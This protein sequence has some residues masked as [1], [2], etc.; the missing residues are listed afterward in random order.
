MKFF[1]IFMC[2]LCQLFAQDQFSQIR[3]SSRKIKEGCLEE[4]KAYYQSA[5]KER[6]EAVLE[7]FANEGMLI[8]CGFIKEENG[9]HYLILFY[10][11]YDMD[12]AIEAFRNST[13]EEDLLHKVFG[14]KCFEH[15]EVLSP[16]YH[17]EA[18]DFS[19]FIMTTKPSL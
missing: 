11:A 13:L 3:C 4:V 17:L 9:S 6:R 10:R 18:E 2:F 5:M 8:E 12:K 7:T 1:V 15:R 16:I 19:N 14:R